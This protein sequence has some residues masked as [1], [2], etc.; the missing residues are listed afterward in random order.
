[1]T[2]RCNMPKEQSRAALK[3]ALAVTISVVIFWLAGG[4]LAT[5]QTPTIRDVER[6]LDRHILTGHEA[7][8]ARVARLEIATAANTEQ[9]WLVRGGGASLGLILIG[10]N[11]LNLVGWRINVVRARG[12][13]GG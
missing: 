4:V 5:S 1:M 9:L 10:L 7:I 12:G 8:E 11:V 6:Q 3:R 13:A 2:F